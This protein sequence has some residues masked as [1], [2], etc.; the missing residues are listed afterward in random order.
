L[1][2]ALEDRPDDVWAERPY[3]AGGDPGRN[4]LF[5]GRFGFK[6]GHRG[7]P[8]FSNRLGRQTVEGLLERSTLAGQLCR[9]TVEDDCAVMD[10]QDPIRHRLDLLK[11]VRRIMTDFDYPSWRINWLT[12]RIC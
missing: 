3:P 5:A 4:P 11:D 9:L 8:L 2:V 1:Q 7:Y 12:T 6:R 10:E